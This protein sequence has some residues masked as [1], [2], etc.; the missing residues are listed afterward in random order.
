M[1]TPHILEAK[2]SELKWDLPLA[3]EKANMELDHYMSIFTG[4]TPPSFEDAEKLS[5]AYDIP[6]GE[7]LREGDSATHLNIG[8]GTYSNSNHG[9]IKEVVYNA[10]RGLAELVKDLIS[11]I[12]PDIVWPE[13]KVEQGDKS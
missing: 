3:A 2:N 4:V 7:F 10:D 11:A 13:K 1:I 5:K 12:K 6:F 9:Y 8:S